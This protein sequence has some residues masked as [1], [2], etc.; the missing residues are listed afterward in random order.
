MLT[1]SKNYSKASDFSSLN[2]NFTHHQKAQSEEH[3]A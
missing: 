3:H 2:T 1:K